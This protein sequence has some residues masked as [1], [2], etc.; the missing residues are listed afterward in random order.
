MA[1]ILVVKPPFE[2]PN[3][4]G[5]RMA[6]RR[7]SGTGMGAGNGAVDQDVLQIRVLPTTLM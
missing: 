2:R 4:F 3:A 1:W 5:I 7:P 6:S